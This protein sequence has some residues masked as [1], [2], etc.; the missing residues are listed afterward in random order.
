MYRKQDIQRRNIRISRISKGGV[1]M[2]KNMDI[3]LTRHAVKRMAERCGYNRRSMY[4]MASRAY[5][6]GIGMEK[7]VGFVKGW[8][9]HIYG[10]NEN[11]DN[12]R[13]YGDKC[14]VFDGM[15][16]ITVLQIP[17]GLQKKVNHLRCA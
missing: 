3:V 11:A 17:T 7:A 6:Q 2:D 5:E 4:R 8:M 16:L 15:E 1:G 13:L 12:L 10:K 14:F 9:E